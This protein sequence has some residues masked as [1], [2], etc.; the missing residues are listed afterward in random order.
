MPNQQNK[1]IVKWPQ[2]DV[3]SGDEGEDLDEVEEDGNDEVFDL[4]TPR[5]VE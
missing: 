2:E 3:G 5:K 4:Q 1:S